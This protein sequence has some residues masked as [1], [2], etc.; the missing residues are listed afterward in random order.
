ML[1][2][3]LVK[4]QASCEHQSL[5]CRGLMLGAEIQSIRALL[6]PKTLSS[7]CHGYCC[8]PSLSLSLL[9]ASHI[10]M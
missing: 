9:V 5:L 2:L 1:M 3:I 6:H 8:P 7:L 10:K 4:V